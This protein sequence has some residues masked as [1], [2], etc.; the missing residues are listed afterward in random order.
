MGG[1]TTPSRDDGEVRST[2]FA[3]Y[4]RWDSVWTG[5]LVWWC[6]RKTTSIWDLCEAIYGTV[7]EGGI[8]NTGILRNFI[9]WV[10]CNTYKR[11]FKKEKVEGNFLR[12]WAYYNSKFIFKKLVKDLLSLLTYGRRF[13]TLSI[14]KVYHW[15]ISGI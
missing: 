11:A 9:D 8:R 1:L 12:N 15:P 3:R 6:R 13:A 2:G 4:R 10:G 7:W 5:N 14:E